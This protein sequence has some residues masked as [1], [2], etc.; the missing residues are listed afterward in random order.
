MPKKRATE[1][2]LVK[3]RDGS[4]NWYE[5][6]T[7]NGRRFRRSLE[8]ADRTEAEARAAKN[9]SE[10]RD[11]KNRL[12]AKSKKSNRSDETRQSSLI[13]R[14]TG[15]RHYHMNFTVRGQRF[16]SSL[17]THNQE[18]A[19]ILAGKIRAEAFLGTLTGKK[20]ELGL[21]QALARYWREHGRYAR[22]SDDIKRFD[23]MLLSGLGEKVL[24]SKITAADLTTYMARRREAGLSNRSVNMELHHLRA[25]INRARDLWK[26]SVPEIVWQKL[27]LEQVGERE[28]ILSEEEEKR[29]FAALRPDFHPMVRFAL[30]TGVR[31]ANVIGLR[32]RQVDWDAGRMVFRVK[33]KKPKGELHYI[34]ITPWVAAILSRERDHHPEWVFTYVCARNRRIPRTGFIQQKGARYP[35]TQDGWRKEWKRALGAAGVE[36][37]RFHDLRHT[38]ATRTLNAHKNLRTVQRMLGHRD[39]TT[40]SRY[41]R[42]DVED[43][44]AAMQA[45]EKSQP[46]RTRTV[47]TIPAQKRQK[48]KD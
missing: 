48:Q 43:V 20:P 32:W 4:P 15:S 45:V 22:S 35:F 6:Y 8:T 44:R 13:R 11:A 41:V 16:R 28:H 21:K 39:I 7:V 30:V 19:E 17:Y 38:G 1:S 34:P 5:N 14:R 3:R 27:R 23:R 37:F 10:A 12:N 40:T 47:G 25:V 42:S 36:D 33:S 26:I 29:L 9:R 31:L 2:G 46:R 18:E 24:L